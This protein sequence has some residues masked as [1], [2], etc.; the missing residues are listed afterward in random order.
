MNS[1]MPPAHL[2][3]EEERKKQ[4]YDEDKAP[5]RDRYSTDVAGLA[6]MGVHISDDGEKDCGPHHSQKKD[7]LHRVKAEEL[8]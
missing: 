6:E 7:K 2:I 3:K 8:L 1:P 5:E 4:G